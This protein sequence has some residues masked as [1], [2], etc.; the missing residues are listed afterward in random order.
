MKLLTVDDSLVMRQLIVQNA[1][2][3]GLETAEARDA[4]EALAVLE[5]EGDS[6]SVILL[7]WNM[8]GMNGYELLKRI[9]QDSRWAKIP[10]MMLTTEGQKSSVVAALK[11]GAVNYMIKP[12]AQEDLSIKIMQCLGQGA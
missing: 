5:R 8:P 7:D 11:A 9:K 10:V 2:T 6:I 12:F 3:L 1:K 4:N